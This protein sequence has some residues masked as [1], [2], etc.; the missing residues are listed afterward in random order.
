MP[1]P[2]DS[3]NAVVDGGFIYVIGGYD[4]SKRS[5]VVQRYDPAT[6]TWASPPPAPLLHA[7]SDSAVGVIGST[8]V[9]AGGLDNVVGASHDVEGYS[10]KTNMWKALESDPTQRD[11]Q[12]GATVGSLL[13]VVGGST[14]AVLNTTTL[15]E[16]Y[17]MSTNKWTTLSPALFA[18]DL[19]MPAVVNGQLFC[20]GGTDNGLPFQGTMFN[21]VQTYQ[22]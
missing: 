5:A 1:T 9:S 13:Y 15:T 2:M 8:I 3:M 20:I 21:F 16:S 11:L 6:D 18:Q 12:C 17:N 14:T 19:A 10:P 22:P 7:K 4:G